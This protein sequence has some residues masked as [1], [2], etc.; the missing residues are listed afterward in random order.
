[1]TVSQAHWF[2][3]ARMSSYQSVPATEN[4]V[5]VEPGVISV[6]QLQL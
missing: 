3:S 2:R 6:S 5:E 4:V 1:V